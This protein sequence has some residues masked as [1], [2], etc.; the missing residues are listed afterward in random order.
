MI[1]RPA[2]GRTLRIRHSN[3]ATYQK[4]AGAITRSQDVPGQQ[5]R[6]LLQQPL[7]QVLALVFGSFDLAELPVR[8]DQKDL[9]RLTRH[10]RLRCTWRIAREVARVMPTGYN[11][12]S[13][14]KPIRWRH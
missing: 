11:P 4:K 7:E 9:V 5:A 10:A 2:V 8:V 3:F 1:Q 12:P 13:D 14:E 6:V